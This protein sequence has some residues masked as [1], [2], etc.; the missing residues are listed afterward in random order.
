MIPIL[1]EKTETTFTSNGIGRLPDCVSCTVTEE[2]NSGVYECDFSY[3]VTGINYSEITIGRIIAVT[4]DDTGDIQPFDIVSYSKPID[5][6]VDFH[7]VHISYR[8][9]RYTAKVPNQTVNSIANAFTMFQNAYPQDGLWNYSAPGMGS[10]TAFMGSTADGLPKSVRQFIGGIEGSFLDTFGGEVTWDKFNVIFKPQRGQARDFTIRY[11]VNLTGYNEEVEGQ[12]TFAYALPY[13]TDGTNVVVGNLVNSGLT[14]YDGHELCVALDLS[15]KFDAAPSVADLTTEATTFM[16]DNATNVP[17]Q[18]INVDFVRIQDLAGYEDYSD[19]L[20]CELG[21]SLTVIFPAYGVQAAFRIVRVEWNALLDRFDL[22]TLGTLQ[23][24]LAEALG[25]S[26]EI[27]PIAGSGGGGATL[28]YGTCT[29]A[30]GTA[31][32]AATITGFTDANITTGQVIFVKFSNANTASNPTL[33]INSG[34]AK[35]IMRYGTTAPSTSA[36]SSWNAGAVV[37]L[38]YDGTNWVMEDWLNTTYSSMTTAEID[39]GT[40]TTARIITPARLKYAI[41]YWSTAASRQIWYG[42]CSTAESSLGKDATTTTGDFMLTAGNFVFITFEHRVG[43]DSGTTLSIDGGTY[44]SVRQ[45]GSA[46]HAGTWQDGE[47][48]GFVYDG[49]NFEMIDVAIASTTDYGIV[50]LNSATNSSSTAEAATPSAVKSAYDLADSKSAVSWS[51][52]YATGTKIAAITING[53]STNVNVPAA[54]NTVSGVVAVEPDSGAYLG[55]YIDITTGNNPGVYRVP[56]LDSSDQVGPHFLP[57]AT[58]SSKGA[59]IVDSSMSGSS[60]NAVR[61]GVIKN[62]VD[63]KAQHLTASL[64]VGHWSANQ[65][66]VSV[67][68]VTATNTVIVTYAPADRAAWLAA[69]VYCSAQSAG[70][71]TFTCSTTP[72]TDLT[73]N[74]LVIDSKAY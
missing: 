43:Y 30:G 68:P 39:A 17:K 48:V 73:A 56:K 29:T 35:S 67:P 34:T 36:A 64:T 28:W 62:Y 74:I 21:D 31:A 59:V 27:G 50:K 4:H 52:D 8:L 24:T 40:G 45:N 54:T 20:T 12:E 55:G 1:Y 25:I 15:D 3:P 38:I 23:T 61:N 71:L 14:D 60:T 2:L 63:E 44:V 13:W 53:T 46:V 58:T 11:G 7:A 33:S 72:T 51:Q 19:L 26:T 18:S 65:Q 9:A 42:T 32:K 41:Q 66:Y 6:V 70:G 69:D 47:T 37:C 57:D 10:P 16:T 49:T 5:G 22:M